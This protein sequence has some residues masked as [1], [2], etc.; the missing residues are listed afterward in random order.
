MALVCGP[1]PGF[2]SGFGNSAGAAVNRCDQGQVQRLG[3][4]SDV[5]RTLTSVCSSKLL[6]GCET[7]INKGGASRQK[8]SGEGIDYSGILV[9]HALFEIE[10]VLSCLSAQL[11]RR[12]VDSG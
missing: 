3:L 2:P 9:V 5:R 8:C 7:K 6:Y 4:D 11:R 1:G 10:C 12:R